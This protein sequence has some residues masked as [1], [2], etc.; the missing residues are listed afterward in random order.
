[1]IEQYIDKAV[2]GICW[3]AFT[4]QMN[5]DSFFTLKHGDCWP[6]NIMWHK[7][8]SVKFIDW[9]M[10]GIGSG[11]E[12][13]GQYVISNMDPEMRRQ[14]E[15]TLLHQ[16]YSELLVHGVSSKD[17]TF[18]KCY[19]DYEIG[20]VERWLW[21]LAYMAGTNCH[22]PDEWFYFFQGQLLAFIKDHNI[23]LA[24]IIQTR[25]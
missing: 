19:H 2:S 9:E 4:K 15:K 23:Q 16:Y 10:T 24:D 12:G 3:D 13:L 5:T 18:E 17:Y 1:M 14:I 22:V 11:P 20:G 8:E 7:D 25:P 6:G 21:F